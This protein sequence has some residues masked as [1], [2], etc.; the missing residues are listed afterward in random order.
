MMEAE[1]LRTRIKAQI[2]YQLSR[3]QDELHDH[4]TEFVVE[5]L[6]WVL[7]TVDELECAE[8]KGLAGKTDLPPETEALRQVVEKEC[9]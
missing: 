9:D 8:K 3:D 1:A 6:E 7:K 5:G 2:G 4:Y